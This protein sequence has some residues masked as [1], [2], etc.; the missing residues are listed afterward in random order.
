M[1]VKIYKLIDREN[2]I[3]NRCRGCSLIQDMGDQASSCF[4][5]LTRN[6]AV[7]F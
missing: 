6:Q 1:R 5:F 7:Q 2:G 3:T 4:V